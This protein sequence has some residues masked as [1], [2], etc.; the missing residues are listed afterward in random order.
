MAFIIMKSFYSC[1]GVNFLTSS[2]IQWT[3]H[4]IFVI[5]WNISFIFDAMVDK[6]WWKNN[7]GT[8]RFITL[9]VILN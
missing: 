6:M 5:Q 8:M 3:S 2:D 4:W 9:V 1:H 7:N